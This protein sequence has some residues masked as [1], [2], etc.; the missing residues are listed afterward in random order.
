MLDNA[1]DDD[2]DELPVDT[3]HALAQ[4]PTKTQALVKSSAN[5]DP[6]QILHHWHPKKIVAEWTDNIDSRHL[7][8]LLSLTSGLSKK[9]KS[10][11]DVKVTKDG[12][13]LTLSEK[14]DNFVLDVESFYHVFPKDPRESDAEYCLRKAAMMTSVSK[15]LRS[16]GHSKALASVYRYKLPFRCDPDEKR[17]T[18]LASGHSRVLHIDLAERRRIDCAQWHR[19]VPPKKQETRDQPEFSQL[20]D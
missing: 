16:Y 9:D 1:K 20:V 6:Q 14:W 7:I 13:E 10:G 12:L 4:L 8:V 2:D 3:A 19:V 18:C 15:L 5:H 17:V 11:I